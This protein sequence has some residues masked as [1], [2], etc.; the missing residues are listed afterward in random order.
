MERDPATTKVEQ[1]NTGRALHSLQWWPSVA[2]LLFAGLLA[3]DMSRGGTLAPVVAAS[4]FVYLGAA[5]LG[6]PAAAWPLFLLS[7]VVIAISRVGLTTIDP[8][9]MLVGLGALLLAYGL[10]SHAAHRNA[11]LSAQAMAM[12][13]FGAIAVFA[14]MVNGALAAYAVATGLFAHAAWDVYHHWT[15]RVVVRS[16]AEFC[17][18]LDTLVA[19]AI[20]V[21][22]VR[23]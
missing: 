5:A 20:V 8:T 23:R 22:T 1:A 7:I 14:A 16:M 12:V 4:G 6:R 10:V 15:N 2:G 21:V 11:A 9:V 3:L 18:V 17:C 13:A 19:V